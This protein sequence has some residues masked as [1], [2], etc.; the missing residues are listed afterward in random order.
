M[1]VPSIIKVDPLSDF[2]LIITF[3]NNEIRQLD[4]RPLLDFGIFR[5]LSD[6]ALFQTARVS[7]DAIE[8]DNEADLDPEYIYKNSVPTRNLELIDNSDK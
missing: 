8:W 4:M 6:L 3:D 5:E 7:F 2:S 1:R